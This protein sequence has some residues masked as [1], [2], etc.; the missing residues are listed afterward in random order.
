MLSWLKFFWFRQNLIDHPIYIKWSPTVSEPVYSFSKHQKDYKL[1]YT[2]SN[3]KPIIVLSK[4]VKLYIMHINLS[5]SGTKRM[6][7]LIKLSRP[8]KCV[9][10]NFEY[11]HQYF[12]YKSD[13]FLC[14]Q[15]YILGS[16]TSFSLFTDFLIFKN[17]Y[18][19]SIN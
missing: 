16:N 10:V 8:S 6:S 15:K 3:W 14:V 12:R 9:N 5:L 18:L 7:H 11:L 4:Q 17:I 19:K 2:H 13:T 1:N